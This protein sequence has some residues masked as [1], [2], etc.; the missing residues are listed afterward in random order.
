[1]NPTFVKLMMMT[2]SD[3]DGEALTAIRKANAALRAAGL[4]WQDLLGSHGRAP[5]PPP[6]PE[7]KWGDVN[8]RGD[9]YDD[10]DEINSL[11]DKAFN[12]ADPSANFY[13]F[14]VSIRTWWENKGWLT[15]KQYRALKRSVEG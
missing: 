3:N 15:E 11:F 1:M 4:N 10:E 14:L 7:P 9:R 5:P 2:T 13:E 12:N 6:R 8:R